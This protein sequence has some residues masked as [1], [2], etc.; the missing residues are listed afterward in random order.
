MGIKYIYILRA[1]NAEDERFSFH[2]VRELVEKVNEISPHKL[3]IS[4]VASYYAGKVKYPKPI[5][6]QIN[7]WRI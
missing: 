7:R 3:N 4:K 2:S 1:N 5:F 6:S